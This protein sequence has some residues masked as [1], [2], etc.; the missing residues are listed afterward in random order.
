M[1]R[2]PVIRVIFSERINPITLNP[3]TVYLY[4]SYTGGLVRTTI[5]IAP[6]RLS[7]TLRPDAPLEPLS[8]YYY[9]V[10][11]FAD[12][13]GNTAGLGAV[14]FRTGTVEDSTPPTVVSIDP[15][16]GATN[17]PVN[18]RVQ[19]VLSESID[20]TVVPTSSVQL[21]PSAA[22]TVVVSTDR[23]TLLF[24]PAANLAV[25]TSYTV[26]ISGLR[27]SSGNTMSP[28]SSAFTTR[29]S[30]TPDTTAPTVV[31]F[32]PSNG[33]TNVAGELADRADRER[34]HPHLRTGRFHASVRE[35]PGVRN[36]P[37]GR[38]IQCQPGRNSRYVH[39]ARPVSGRRAGD[40]VLELRLHQHG[41]GWKSAAAPDSD[42]Y[43][44]TGRRHDRSDGRHGDAF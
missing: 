33:A 39:A 19:V 16:N 26:Q 22:G 23:R 5:A 13:A 42:V 18:T 32:S 40:G 30:S 8:N 31:S 17:V 43:H 34:G 2:S 21:T 20:T 12:L 44:C 11:P 15:T 14:Y 37:A 10:S 7:L 27:D 25:S 35:R 1:G 9:V 4:N 38:D 6:D 41:S 36:R 29:A 24:T 3:T 28:V